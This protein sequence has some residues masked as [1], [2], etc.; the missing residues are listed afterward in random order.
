MNRVAL[1]LW[2]VGATAAVAPAGGSIGQPRASE[3]LERFV[4]APDTAAALALVEATASSGLDL[5][6][7]LARL[8]AGRSYEPAPAGVSTVT[9][10]ASD[11]STLEALVELPRSY[12]PDKRWPVRVQLH[13]GVS[14]P[15]TAGPRRR[16][17][18][19]RLPGEEAIY[20]QP[21]GHAGAEWWHLNQFEHMVALLDRV[22]RSYNVD[23]NLVYL[24]GVSDGAT[25]AYFYAM[26]LSTPFSAFMPLNGN[27]R[28]LSSPGTRANG[29]LHAG[30]MI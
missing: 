1:V 20:V 19:N 14:R 7:A 18:P 28:V 6:T 12:V 4:Q 25:G 26:K 3:T 11:N 27:M 16:L 30:N 9:F 10:T 23:E 29:Q 8:R 24:T 15:E 5:E 22:K 17:T 21:T 13:G 2:L